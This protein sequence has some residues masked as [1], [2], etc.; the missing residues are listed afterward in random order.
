[1][2][3]VY[4][5]ICDYTGEYYIGGTTMEFSARFACHRSALKH[6]YGPPLLQVCWDRRGDHNF[7]FVPLVELPKEEVRERELEMIRE[8]RPAL[9]HRLPAHDSVTLA[10]QLTGLTRNAIRW[11]IRNGKDATAAP[12]KRAEV[13]GELLTAREIADRYGLP[14]KLVRERLY[15][16]ETGERM[17]RPAGARS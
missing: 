12:Y 10:T 3:G 6:G 16:G 11:R 2:A 17:I 5:I 4:M 15:A 9:N 1:M 14:L 13:R 7:R 8:L